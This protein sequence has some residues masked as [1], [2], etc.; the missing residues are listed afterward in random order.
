M[1]T[2]QWSAVV[3]AAGVGIR[4]PGGE[5]KPLPQ[6][7][8]RIKVT[9]TKQHKSEK[10]GLSILVQTQVTEGAQAGEQARVYLGLDFSKDGVKKSWRAALLSI[11]FS[12]DQIDAGD[13]QIGSGTF[14]GAQGFLFVKHRQKG[15][16]VEVNHDFITEQQYLTYTES[17]ESTEAPVVSTVVEAPVKSAIAAPAKA[18]AKAEVPAVSVTVPTPAGGAAARLRGMTAKQ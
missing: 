17:L 12:A 15:E 11:G 9:E 5:Y 6:G 2:E 8:Y 18:T 16:E 3:N 7:A 10:G 14:E 4:N 1:A 13:M